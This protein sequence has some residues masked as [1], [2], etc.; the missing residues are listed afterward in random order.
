[1][2]FYDLPKDKRTQLVEKIEQEI[3]DDLENNTTPS[4][5]KYFSD[6]DTYI[7]KSAYLAFG[8]IYFTNKN[9]QNKI[10]ATLQK[11]F[12][13]QD[14]KVRQT[15]VN[16]F[17]EIGKKEA[18]DVLQLYESAML[19]KNHSVRNAVIGSLKKMGEKNPKPVLTF[20][21]KFIH[22]KNPEVRRIVA[23]GIELRGRT[24]PEEV[25]PLLE[26]MQDE[27]NKRVRNIVVHVLGQ[28]SY[29]QGCLE[30]IIASLKK[31]KN[32]K[33]VDSALAEILETHKSYEKFSDKTYKVAKEYIDR[34]M[35]P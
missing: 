13:D 29:K 23:H 22:H 24:H 5:H 30:K 15:V 8:R 11:E 34:H 31:W 32:K 35:N 25:L 20:S 33:I 17:G 27:P 19:D 16:A 14:E 28:I 3:Q 4:L 18:D 6:D 2:S 10:V 26:E 21:K 12:L 9:L 7:R 1:M